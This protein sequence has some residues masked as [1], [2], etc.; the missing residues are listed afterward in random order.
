MASVLVAP[1]V[2]NGF[3]F[4]FPD[5]GGYLTR[6]LEGR[7][8]LGRSAFYGLFLDA[9]IPFGFW[10]NVI[11]QS[12]LTI[13]LIVLTLRVLR[14]GGRPWLAF[15]IALLLSVATSLPW[16]TGQ[17]L[18]DILFPLA[19]LAL[20]LLAFHNDG[21]AM[22]ERVALACVVVFAIVSHMAAAAL[23]VGLVAALW[24]VGR[25]PGSGLLKPRLCYAASAVIAGVVLCPM[26]NWAITGTFAFTP[27]GSSFLF[28]RLVEDGIVARYLE[29]RCPDP[30]IRLCAYQADMPDIADDWLWDP[31]SP[32]RK[33]GGWEQLGN[34]ERAIILATLVR[35]PLD[36]MTAA[37]SDTVQQLISFRTEVSLDDNEPTIGVI[38]DWTPRLL[39]RFMAARQQ[40]RGI[41]V[42]ALNLVDVPVAAL[43]MIGMLG[44]LLARRRLQLTPE[45]GALCATTLL[46]LFINAAIC[47]IFSHPVDRYQSRLAPLALF[48]VTLVAIEWQ[49]RRG[50]KA[51]ASLF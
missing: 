3:P 16:L 23:C 36:Q 39:P 30:T 15:G 29:D 45:L 18:P 28:G 13:F 41:D 31:D 22:W 24:L 37:V 27:G 7:L 25:L 35:Y 6:P 26:S 43:A 48:A 14:F 34:E 21:L 12:A 47:G 44:A 9:G 33:L 19:V 46:A 4:I 32:F 10:P 2:W 17:L 11:A 50:E 8:E 42:G 20:Y 49:R 40:R 1:A 38:H 51:V 5:T